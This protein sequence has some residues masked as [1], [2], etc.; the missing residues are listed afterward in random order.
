MARI[1][2]VEKVGKDS[3]RV[4]YALTADGW[5]SEHLF[6]HCTREE[7]LRAMCAHLGIAPE[8]STAS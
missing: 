4:T 6:K 8:Q 3:F 1:I 2:S 7:A 5:R